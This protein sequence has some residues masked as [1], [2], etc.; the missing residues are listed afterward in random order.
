MYVLRWSGLFSFIFYYYRHRILFVG[1]KLNFQQK[2]NDIILC[3]Y[4]ILFFRETITGG[5]LRVP[6]H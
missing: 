5:D 3:H 6:V 4:F 1:T 2:S